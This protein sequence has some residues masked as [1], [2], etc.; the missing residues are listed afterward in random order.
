MSEPDQ[1]LICDV[2]EPIEDSRLVLRSQKMLLT[3]ERKVI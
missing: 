2:H 1:V 3:R